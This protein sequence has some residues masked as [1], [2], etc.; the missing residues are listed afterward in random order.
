MNQPATS[1]VAASSRPFQPSLARQTSRSAMSANPN[2]RTSSATHVG[3]PAPN[4]LADAAL[5]LHELDRGER[6]NDRHAGP[7]DRGHDSRRT[8]AASPLARVSGGERQEPA[9][10]R[11]D[12]GAEEADPQHQVLD[13]GTGTGN[14]DADSAAQDDFEQRDDRHHGQRDRRDGV[15][16]TRWRGGSLGLCRCPGRRG[17]TGRR[18]CRRLRFGG[19]ALAER[20]ALLEGEIED[21]RRHHLAAHRSD[22]GCRRVAATRGRCPS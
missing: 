15:L 4:E 13:D 18:G 14:A 5:R 2:G 20:V 17:G 11:R 10:A 22:R 8:T 12:G 7:D 9:F 6:E 1:P 16:D 3:M 21:V 19:L